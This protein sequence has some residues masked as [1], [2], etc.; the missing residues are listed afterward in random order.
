MGVSCLFR[1]ADR[2]GAARSG[3]YW[4]LARG[5]IV[6]KGYGV[7]AMQVPAVTLDPRARNLLQVR[8]AKGK[9]ALSVS[10]LR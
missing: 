10:H 7:P 3:H 6:Q 8:A 5:G 1:D 2:R 9:E 4:R